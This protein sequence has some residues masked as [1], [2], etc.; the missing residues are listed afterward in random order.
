MF[1][2]FLKNIS[3]IPKVVNFKDIPQ[4][5]RM[6]QRFFTIEQYYGDIIGMNVDSIEFCPNHKP[7]ELQKE[8]LPWL[9]VIR[10]EL[11]NQLLEIADK[12]L[13]Q[14]IGDYEGSTC[15]T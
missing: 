4:F 12:Q 11:K 1:K 14:I 9:W 5:D 7:P 15:A 3:E 6:E 10:P 2:T 8:I 13:Q